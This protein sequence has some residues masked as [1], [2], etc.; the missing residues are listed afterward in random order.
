[1]VIRKP[2]Y[3]KETPCKGDVCVVIVFDG[4]LN[5]YRSHIFTGHC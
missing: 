3:S 2:E 5:T 4:Q 1:M